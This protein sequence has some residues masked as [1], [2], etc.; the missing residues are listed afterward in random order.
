M[1]VSSVERK[2]KIMDEINRT[3]KVKVVDLADFFQVSTETIRRDLDQ[4]E[5]SGVLKRVYG[6]AV[7]TTYKIEPP[8][9]Q[10]TGVHLQEKIRIGHKAA[11]LVSDGDTI[12]IDVGTTTLEFARALKHKRE[13]TIF[14]NSIPVASVIMEALNNQ[15]LTGELILLG[16]S[17]NPTQ[18]STSGPLAVSVLHQF[19][20]DKAFISVGG[21]S[22]KNGVSDYDL[23]E[24]FVSKAMIEASNDTIV[25]ADHSKIGN[26][27]FSR[28]CSI[29]KIDVIVS[30][31]PMPDS[32]SHEHAANALKWIV[33]DQTC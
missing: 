20:I 28:I 25:L 22:V 33:A 5:E 30:D 26:Q 27:A 10:R 14:T 31:H 21:I 19:H 7:K 3:G 13:L 15:E 18:R 11:E 16:G 24:S 12:V 1:S 29:D 6:G 9:S 17:V 32:W 8:F 2:K 4:L 23:E